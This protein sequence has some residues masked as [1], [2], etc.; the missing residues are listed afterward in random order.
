MDPI[1]TQKKELAKED[2]QSSLGLVPEQQIT[3]EML[4]AIELAKPVLDVPVQQEKEQQSSKVAEQQS[5]EPVVESVPVPES[6][7]EVVS[8]IEPIPEPIIES[9]PEVEQ[10]KEVIEII[11]EVVPEQVVEQ[12]PQ[13][14]VE[15]APPPRP[16][17]I[18]P[19]PPVKPVK[20][21][22]E[23]ELED[24]LEEDLKDM[25][26]AMPKE[27]QVEFR[28]KGEETVSAIRQ[29]LVDT[30]KN[31]K[32]IFQLIRAWL[33]IIPGVNRYF[34]EQEAKI[35]TDKILFVADEEKRRGSKL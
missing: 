18:I 23:Q 2:P 21:K 29:L 28:K 11:P 27:K 20:D 26:L 17:P 5:F 9:V 22:L 1:A 33:K 4:S 15:Q 30:H 19:V 24:V 32:K 6:I 13:P 35:K 31:V 7:P 8:V 14:I 25:Y 10:P 16:A 3:P 12:A 34:L